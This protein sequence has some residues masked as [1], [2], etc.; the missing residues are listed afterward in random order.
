MT[1]RFRSA[2]QLGSEA[3]VDLY[4]I[5]T[6][7]YGGGI[8]YWTP[9]PMG[10]AS[11]NLIWNAR[12]RSNVA[13]WSPQAT[14]STFG[15]TAVVQAGSPQ[16]QL[17]EG[18]AQ[19]SYADIEADGTR[20]VVWQEW[21]Q[22]APGQILHAQAFVQPRGCRVRVGVQFH[23]GVAIISG[24]TVY[25][26]FQGDLSGFGA[27]SHIDQFA[28]VWVNATV[29]AGAQQARLILQGAPL[30]PGAASGPCSWFFARSMFVACPVAPTAPLAF[31]PG[32]KAGAVRFDG[33]TYAPLPIRFEGL[34]RTGRG[35]VPRVTLVVPDVEGLATALMVTRGNLLG[36]PIKRRQAFRHALDDGDSPDPFDFFGPEIFYVDRVARWV[37]GVE[38]ALECASPLDIQGTMLPGR[39]VIADVCGLT[40]RRWNG[41]A[42][43]YGSC[44]YAGASYFTATNASTGSAAEDVCSKSLA[45]CR[46]R[47]GTAVELPAFMFPGVSRARY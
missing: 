16:W 31:A 40:Y 18:S 10:E 9:G 32:A 13:G 1:R 5:D 20:N 23:T 11:G 35:P 26:A 28:Q 42:F 30:T 25:S 6:T 12:C 19:V 38:V 29:P 2:Q 36:C 43:V 45:G 21:A 37:P 39:Q 15:A 3:L 41:A 22:V 44:P 7:K 46:A 34:Q 33:Q 14:A 27:A 8:T 4:E 47:Y 24:A 17:R